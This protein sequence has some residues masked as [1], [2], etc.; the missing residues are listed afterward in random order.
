MTA[1]PQR[2]PAAPATAATLT[3]ARLAL[4]DQ[5]IRRVARAHRLNREDAEDFGQTVHLKLLERGYDVF[6]VFE[7]RSTLSTY[8]HVVVTRLL[9][10]WRNAT[11]GKWRPSAAALRLGPDAV[12][13]ERLMYRDGLT[14]GEAVRSW[15]SRT[16]ADA[17]AV[18]A[19]DALA[20]TL[21]ARPTRAFLPE[22]AA[23]DSAH[24][25]FEDPVL[26]E[27]ARQAW[28]DVR[29]RLRRACAGLPTEE[30]QLLALRFGQ[31][32]TVQAIG[33]RLG[34]NPK[35]LY[36][37]LERS[38]AKLRRSLDDDAPAPAALQARR[39]WIQEVRS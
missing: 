6:G 4:L 10:D 24:V 22:T 3:P 25:D 8:L 30:R 11:R 28:R 18:D 21:P 17:A 23:R 31:A 33:Q 12:A 32:L 9:L 7:G 38:L 16:A 2:D 20:A 19:L 39:A 13:L 1:H 36:R 5:V 27:E 26:A 34:T 15:A 29:S 14:A 37:R 35:P